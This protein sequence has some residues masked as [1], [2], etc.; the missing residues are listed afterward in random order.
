ML[1][2]PRVNVN[3]KFTFSKLKFEI[4]LFQRFQAINEGNDG[5][6]HPIYFRADKVPKD[7]S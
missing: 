3:T 5:Y 7:L 6:R 1:T 4:S 2:N